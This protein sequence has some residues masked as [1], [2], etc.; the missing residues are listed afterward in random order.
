MNLLPH[1]DIKE[2]A[3]IQALL[4]D[5]RNYSWRAI[6]S[7]KLDTFT[8]DLGLSAY[9]VPSIVRQAAVAQAGIVSRLRHRFWQTIEQ[10]ADHTGPRYIGI[11]IY[12]AAGEEHPLELKLGDM[13]IGRIEPQRQDNR[14]HLIVADQVVEFI[15]EMEVLQVSAVG[16]GSY[17]IESFVLLH[18]R[19]QPSRYVPRIE[20]LSHRLRKTDAGCFDVELHFTTDLAAAV[21]ARLLDAA[22]EEIGVTS[23]RAGRLHQ[24]AFAGLMPDQQLVA[25]I[26][27][28]DLSGETATAAL[29]FATMSSQP[30]PAREIVVP[31]EIFS[32]LDSDLSGLPLTFGL[33]FARGSATQLDDC[34]LRAGD[35]ILPANARIQSRWDDGSAQWALIETRVP[36]DVSAATLHS[37]SER[38]ADAGFREP[39]LSLDE[40]RLADWRFCAGLGDGA[41][42]EASAPRQIQREERGATFVIEYRD[43]SGVTWLR[44]KLWLLFFAGQRFVR[45]THRL[46]VLAPEQADR[47]DESDSLLSLREFSLR[48]PFAGQHVQH[49]GQK[50]S[51]AGDWQLRH[52]HDQWHEICG[53]VCAGRAAGHVRVAGESGSLGIGLRHFWQ[54]YPKALMVDAQGIDIGLFPERAGRELPGDA[55]APHRLYFWLDDAGYKLKKG[56][57]LTSD[58]LLDFGDDSRVCDWLEA[59]PLARPPIDYLNSARALPP[60]GARRDSPL[61]S[62]EALTD[63]AL[64]SFVDDRE[65]HRAYGQLNFGDW[66]GESGWSWG[67][68]EYDSAYCGYSEFLRGGDAGWAVWARQAARHLADVDT[69]NSAAD[70]TNIGGQAMHIPGHLGGYLPPFFR[71]KM[72]GT[73][74]IPSHTWVEG[75]LLHWLL[76]GDEAAGESLQKTRDWLLQARFFD[77]YDFSNARE[78]GWHLIHLCALAWLD[79]PAALNAASILVARVLERQAPGGGWL[80]MLTDSHCGCGYPRCRGAAGFMVGVLL[81]GLMRYYRHTSDPAVADAIVGGARWLIANTFDYDSGYFRYTSCKN[82]TLGGKFQCTQWVLEGLAAAWTISGDAEIGG[83]LQRGLAVIGR[84]PVGIGH[85]GMGKAMAQQMRYVPSILASLNETPLAFATGTTGG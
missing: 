9:P 25:H 55:D 85:S 8:P 19:P 80:R 46:E 39:G 83:Y 66:Y 18:E 70:A 57:A 7:E 23:G 50:W 48:I 36:M 17:R 40:L 16:S 54:T 79:D 73:S 51:L 44:S 75:P 11:V 45:L 52:D 13:D 76:T 41:M 34:S 32:P 47:S 30:Q 27:A 65:E 1:I 77:A 69:V 4:D 49:A 81:S 67:N 29:E 59:P 15:G 3:R 2:P 68:N 14:A 37:N 84:F 6:D 12:L 56:L 31:L 20:R 62:Y 24:L 42:L 60:I 10:Q 72:R 35:E 64:Q 38:C 26:S 5:P 22:G 74:L 33:P 58:I 63:R 43:A 61:P 82:R 78:A 71:S 53:E 21:E 28:R